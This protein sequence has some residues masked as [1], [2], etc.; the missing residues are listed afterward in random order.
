MPEKRR[1]LSVR[2][3][4]GVRENVSVGS[5]AGSMPH[6][7]PKP[8]CLSPVAARQPFPP[9]G[10][11]ITVGENLVTWLPGYPLKLFTLF[12]LLRS[13]D[14]FT[15]VYVLLIRAALIGC[16]QEVWVPSALAESVGET[17]FSSTMT[18]GFQQEEVTL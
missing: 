6:K 10:N 5:A 7:P 9:K 4:V 13:R 18:E 17:L 2:A 15:R 16:T 3:L 1:F 12:V 14:F 8:G 11:R